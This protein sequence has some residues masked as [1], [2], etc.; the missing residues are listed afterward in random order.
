[1][2][3][4]DWVAIIPSIDNLIGIKFLDNSIRSCQHHLVKE[5]LLRVNTRV[6]D[7][8]IT[9]EARKL[10]TERLIERRSDDDIGH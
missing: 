7:Q 5:N 3:L 2:E 6:V 9:R 8:Y 4:Y 10:H 1:M